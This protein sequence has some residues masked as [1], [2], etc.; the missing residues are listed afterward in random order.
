M[1]K[2]KVNKKHASVSSCNASESQEKFYK[3]TYKSVDCTFNSSVEDRYMRVMHLSLYVNCLKT[4]I[5]FACRNVGRYKICK[6][7]HHKMLC[8]K[9]TMPVDVNVL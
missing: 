4:N 5:H 6:E 1:K 8:E 3:I 7:K 9:A 2:A